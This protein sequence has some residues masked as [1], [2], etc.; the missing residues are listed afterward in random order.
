MSPI[1]ALLLLSS[2]ECEASRYSRHCPFP[3]N[4]SICR[5]SSECGNGQCAIPIDEKYDEKAQYKTGICIFKSGPIG[6]YKPINN[7]RVEGAICSP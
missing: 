7:G 2:G 4:G 1:I 6:C 5:D 3:E